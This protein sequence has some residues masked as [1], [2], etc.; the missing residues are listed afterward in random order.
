MSDVT[1]FDPHQDRRA[2]M[3]L[4]PRFQEW[5]EYHRTRIVLLGG[6]AEG[7]GNRSHTY[8]I[9]SEGSAP[10]GKTICADTLEPLE[11]TADYFNRFS[12]AYGVERFFEWV[13]TGGNDG[14]K[15]PE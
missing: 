14:E 11:N 15:T 12:R 5:C 13:T 1:H 7:W 8:H 4:H 3:E 9:V 10:F 2:E 6:R